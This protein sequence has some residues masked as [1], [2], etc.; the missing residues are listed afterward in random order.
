MRRYG[1][2]A[3][4]PLLY[5][6]AEGEA[7]PDEALRT[8][9]HLGDCTA[10]RILLARERRLA[11]LLEGEI[12]DRLPVDEGF[13]RMV[14]ANLPHEPPRRPPLR[15]LIPARGGPIFASRWATRDDLASRLPR[16]AVCSSACSRPTTAES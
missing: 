1:C 9:R 13:V 14:M 12:E 11:E 8:A 16:L 3:I 5:R 10:C 2:A 15:T 6:V 7:D 4:R